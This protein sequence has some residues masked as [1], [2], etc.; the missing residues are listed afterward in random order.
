[1]RGERLRPS[2]D[3]KDTHECGEHEGCWRGWHSRTPDTG[4]RCHGPGKLCSV[5]HGSGTALA[6]APRS[7][8]H[9]CSADALPTQ[10][11]P[12]TR[13]PGVTLEPYSRVKLGGAAMREGTASFGEL[14]R[15]LRQCRCSLPG[16]AG[17]ADR[18]EPARDQRSGARGTPRAAPLHDP[19]AGRRPRS[20]SGRPGGTSHRRATQDLYWFN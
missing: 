5:G 20:P 4:P 11:A 1:M 7:P 3:H 18:A 13:R 15:R 8:P 17:R 16:G 6:S 12:T 14:L 2:Y 19:S 9:R 10:S